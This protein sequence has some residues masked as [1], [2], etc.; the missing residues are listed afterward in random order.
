MR[1]GETERE[2]DERESAK[3]GKQTG[4][5]ERVREREGGNLG[6]RGTERLTSYSSSP[7]SLLPSQMP[8]GLASLTT[9]SGEPAHR[10]PSPSDTHGLPR[11]SGAGE[12]RRREGG[13]E[14]GKE[15]GGCVC[16]ITK[17]IPLNFLPLT[18]H[19]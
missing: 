3:G 10:G 15:G 14:G 5:S 11:H 7:L 19:H 1:S 8:R 4:N 17:E 16:V 6:R 13:S 18:N 9:V 2:N 12:K